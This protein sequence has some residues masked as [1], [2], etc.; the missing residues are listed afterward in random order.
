M[1][2][3]QVVI[4]KIASKELRKLH[5]KE[6]Q[7]IFSKIKGLATNPRPDGCKKLKSQSENLW[8]LRMGDYRVIYSIDDTIRIIDIRRVGHRKDIYL[9]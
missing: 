5:K 2:D 6:V 7:L 3:Y 1:R 4:S 9:K 8:R